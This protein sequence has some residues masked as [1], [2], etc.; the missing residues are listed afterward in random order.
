MSTKAAVALAAPAEQ[1]RPLVRRAVQLGSPSDQ[2]R[3]GI[4]EMMKNSNVRIASTAII[5][6]VTVAPPG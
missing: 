1:P 2:A 6:S 5:H 3:R 4:S